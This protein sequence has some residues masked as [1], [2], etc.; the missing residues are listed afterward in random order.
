VRDL[1]KVTW[2]THELRNGEEGGLAVVTDKR[3]GPKAR[4]EVELERAV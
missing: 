2:L 4:V 3:D 1:L